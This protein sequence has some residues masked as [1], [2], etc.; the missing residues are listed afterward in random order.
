[1]RP[2]ILH[3]IDELLER[4]RAQGRVDLND[5]DEVIGDRAVS[6]EEVEHIVDRL[7]AEGLEVGEPVDEHDI[8]VIRQVLE[9]AR[10]LRASLDRTPTVT[11]IARASG[12]PAHVVRRS[13]ERGLSNRPARAPS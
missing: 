2:V 7:E 10:A 13:L 11:E 9:H 3:I 4:H 12:H 6:Y 5:I 8:G 1:M